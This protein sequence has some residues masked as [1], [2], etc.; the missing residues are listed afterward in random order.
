MKRLLNC[1]VAA[2]L[3]LGCSEGFWKDSKSETEQ[4]IQ[5]WERAG[6]PTGPTDFLTDA[7]VNHRESL[8]KA[9]ENDPRPWPNQVQLF[10]IQR[11]FNI[12]PDQK[13]V[14]EV[15]YLTSEGWM[16][17]EEFEARVWQGIEKTPDAPVDKSGPNCSTN[18]ARY[19]C[20]YGIGGPDNATCLIP[21]NRHVTMCL[22]EN[23][24]GEGFENGGFHEGMDFNHWWFRTH[25]HNGN[26][27][28]QGYDFV[29]RHPQSFDPVNCPGW[30]GP[31]VCCAPDGSNCAY[32]DFCADARL[33]NTFPT[34]TDIV[35]EHEDLG[36]GSCGWQG[37]SPDGYMGCTSVFIKPSTYAWNNGCPNSGAGGEHP[38]FIIAGAKIQFDMNR[39]YAHAAAYP[40]GNGTEWDRFVMS[41]HVMCHERG[42]A[43]G[44]LHYDG[45]NSPWEEPSCMAKEWVTPLETLNYWNNDQECEVEGNTCTY[46]GPTYPIPTF[47]PPHQSKEW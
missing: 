14:E 38:Y 11:G 33:P 1:V 43:L 22:L 36:P 10:E 32:K 44:L 37:A 16:R 26:S 4:A 30:F 24:W 19:P 47:R 42:H 28:A 15:S 46:F 5:E 20:A 2:L 31:G 35:F 17:A 12:G 23:P 27:Q 41:A 8:R 39:I 6:K 40:S 29:W 18:L 25:G 45:L 3:L 13:L 9:V 21:D 34:H 7:E